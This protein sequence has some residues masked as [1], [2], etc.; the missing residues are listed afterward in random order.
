M[1]KKKKKNKNNRDELSI[2]DSFDESSLQLLFTPVFSPIVEK[3]KQGNLTG[4][5]RQVKDSV[6]NL[7]NATLKWNTLSQTGAKLI[8]QIANCKLQAIFKAEDDET[9]KLQMMPNEMESLCEELLKLIESMK[10]IVDKLNSLNTKFQN[11]LKLE[12]H[13]LKEN[14]HS[15]IPFQ[16]WTYKD[17]ETTSQKIHE[18]YQME[19]I[20]KENLARNIA[21]V[22]DRH[23]MM[24]CTSAWTYEPYISG[25]CQALLEALVLE[26]GLR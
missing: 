21:H 16:S 23:L 9:R 20:L 6:A 24:F 18:A 5:V 8:G 26:T 25:E 3:P 13:H 14:V 11:L 7:Y 10:Q 4:C 17:Y 1:S 19:Y 22:M 15:V 2:T 12:E